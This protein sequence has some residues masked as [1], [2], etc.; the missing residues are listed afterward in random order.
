MNAQLLIDAIVR[1]TTVLIAQLATTGGIRAPLAH[2]ANQ[3]FVELSR[4]LDQQGVSRK[5]CADMFGM[6]LRAYLRK[7]QRLSESTTEHGRSLWEAVYA[8]LGTREFVT[9]MEI[10]E[11]FAKDDEALLRGVLHDLVENGLV[12]QTGSGADAV[13]RAAS[14]HEL[15]QM[16]RLNKAGRPD[17]LVWALVYHNGPVTREQLARAEGLRNGDLDES[18]R[19]LVAEGRIL[20][21]THPDGTRYTAQRLVLPLGSELGWEAAVL[22]HFY[23]MVTTICSK[24]S[25]RLAML[26]DRVGG[27]TYRFEVW[28]GHPLEQE[29]LSSLERFRAAHSDLRARVRAHNDSLAQVPTDAYRVVVYGGQHVTP[30]E[31]EP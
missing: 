23:A 17:E 2:L 10:L 5:V 25:T 3:V 7:I 28:N 18:L 20:G 27:S 29:V 13:L 15:G 16:R 1:Q 11:R 21:E 4:E 22:D 30:T 19:R 31:E 9:R 26:E 8:F 12:L 24:L 14:E 6:A